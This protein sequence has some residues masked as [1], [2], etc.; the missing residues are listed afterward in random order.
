MKAQSTLMTIVVACGLVAGAVRA[1]EAR[2]PSNGHDR[3]SLRIVDLTMLASNR[4]AVGTN[5]LS[6]RAVTNFVDARRHTFDAI[7]VHGGTTANAATQA[8]SSVLSRIA[9]VGVPLFLVEKD[10]E[11]VRRERDEQNSVH[12]V[13]VG[14]GQI[15]FLR[16]FWSG[17]KTET[18]KTG[19]PA[20]ESRLSWDEETG[21]YEIEKIELGLFGERA[22]LMYEQE[23]GD[24]ET[25]RVGIQFKQE[26]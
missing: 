13:E 12:T 3:A 9:R 25:G 16:R 2:S 7:A 23:E 5:A 24:D 6:L 4:V 8:E 20:L 26:W 18:D 11:Y 21:T 15:E 14:S 19:I 1:G 10:G 17:G 22:W